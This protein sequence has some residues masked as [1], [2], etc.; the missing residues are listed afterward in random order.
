MIVKKFQAV[1]STSPI[2]V[3]SFKQNNEPVHVVSLDK[4]FNDSIIARLSALEVAAQDSSNNSQHLL[5]DDFSDDWKKSFFCPI[6]RLFSFITGDYEGSGLVRSNADPT[7]IK[8]LKLFGAKTVTLDMN[9][10][11][12]PY[13]AYSEMGSGTIMGIENDID[14]FIPLE[15]KL[16]ELLG[17]PTFIIPASQKGTKYKIVRVGTSELTYHTKDRSQLPEMFYNMEFALSALNGW[18][19][20]G[21]WASSLLRKAYDYISNLESVVEMAEVVIADIDKQ[22]YSLKLTLDALNLH[23]SREHIL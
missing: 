20:G 23:V 12:L 1:T 5:L 9:E 8:L 7:D 11:M 21:S 2:N 4:S 22:H 6:M 18:A 15:N 16:R 10:N 19:A 3:T 14:L 13:V 17:D